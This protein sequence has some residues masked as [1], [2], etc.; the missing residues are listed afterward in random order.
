MSG[1]SACFSSM[2]ECAVGPVSLLDPG[3]PCLY[4]A[5]P[6]CSSLFPSTSLPVFP[7]LGLKERLEFIVLL[8]RACCVERAVLQPLLRRMRLLSLQNGRFPLLLPRR[9]NLRGQPFWLTLGKGLPRR[10]L[11]MCMRLWRVAERSYPW[12]SALYSWHSSTWTIRG[13]GFVKIF[14]D[15]EYGLRYF[16]F[17]K[18]GSTRVLWYFFIEGRG[19]CDLKVNAGNDK[20]WVWSARDRSKGEN[21]ETVVKFA[22]LFRHQSLP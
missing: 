10:T 18:H 7:F 17:Q 2:L 5:L 8:L 3:L 14:L 13:S 1:G 20:C 11:S 19:F 22:L 4:K 12:N 15:T 21:T 16:L 9:H 6:S